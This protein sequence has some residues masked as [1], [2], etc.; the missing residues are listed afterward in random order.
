MGAWIALL[1]GAAVALALGFLV[2]RQVIFRSRQLKATV[3]LLKEFNQISN[4]WI[5]ETDAEHRFTRFFGRPLEINRLMGPE[6]TGRTRWEVVGAD[7]SDP[8]W[9]AHKR[10][11]DSQLPIENFEYTVTDDQG[12][13]RWFLITGRPRFDP[14][15]CFRGYRGTA[16]EITQQKSYESDLAA[17]A[18]QQQSVADLSQ[19]ALAGATTGDLYRHVA[20]TVPANLDVEFAAVVELDQ[21]N[22]VLKMRAGFGWE[23]SMYC[24]PLSDHTMAR[25]T[26]EKQDVV[27][28][29]DFSE[30]QRFRLSKQALDH[31]IVSGISVVIGTAS[32]RYGVLQA[33]SKCRRVFDKHDA[34]YF[35][36][37]AFVLAAAIEKAEAD[38]ALRVR[39]RALEAI[40]QGITIADA[41]RPDLPLVYA[42]PA[43]LRITGYTLDEVLGRNCRFLQG[44]NSKESTVE[45]IRSAV[46]ARAHYQGVV[47]NYRKDGATFWNDLTITPVLNPDGEVTHYVGV[48]ADI[49]S[50]IELETQLRQ[51]QKLEAIG[52]L[53]GGVAHDFNNLLTV[54]LG[55]AEILSTRLGQAH[56]LSRSSGLIL[57]AAERGADLTQR[58]LAF[59]RKQSLMPEP[60]DVN[61]AIESMQPML[62]RTIGEQITLELC[63]NRNI[64]PVFA[65]RSQL[66]TAVLN[67]VL[68]AKDAMKSGGTLTIGT[69]DVRPPANESRDQELVEIFVTDTGAGMGPEISRRAFEPFFTTKPIGEGSGLGLSMVHGFAAQSGGEFCISSEP[70]S[71]T[72]ARI[73]LP[74]PKHVS[75]LQHTDNAVSKGLLSRGNGEK[76]L[77]VEDEPHVREFASA[78]LRKIG[79]TAINASSGSEASRL[80][81]TDIDI[82]LLFTDIVLPDGMSGVEL[83]RRAHQLRPNLPVL[84]TSGYAEELANIRNANAMPLLAKPY[85]TGQLA[86]MVR[87]ALNQDRAL[88]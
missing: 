36:S 35:Q 51:S 2:W 26:L 29:T 87:S 86:R 41:T 82:A 1:V 6:Q 55:N 4:D 28:T 69:R 71:G 5:W 7:P 81:E 56:P 32:K 22:S 25:F 9:L 62:R 12:N 79:Y 39:E 52:Q 48:Q 38:A 70:G 47:L 23:D 53:T 67:L 80:L 50:R 78:Q 73:R 59:G 3:A 11:M 61:A 66:E 18:R 76:I 46:T 40:G 31:G 58:L 21:E 27:W 77:V 68:N 20:E 85:R 60:F 44:T 49:T 83:V 33:F 24:K 72:V 13:E 43:F 64:P 63:L 14:S 65:D 45:N 57:N 17:R 15:G 30:E 8:K 34:N 84:L 16:T 37:L 75:S 19:L 74:V 10:C 88:H 42:N 54:I